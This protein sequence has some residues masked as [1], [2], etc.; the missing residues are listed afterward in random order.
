[1]G[2]AIHRSPWTPEQEAYLREIYPDTPNDEVVRLMDERFGTH[3]T[4][5]SVMH[6][7]RA[8]GIGKSDTFKKPQPCWFWTDEKIAWFREFVP[9]HHEHE[10]SAEHERLYGTPLTASQI[11]NAKAKFGVK[12]G[13]VGGQLRK[14][15]VP[16]N[17]GRTWDECGISA[18]SRERILKTAFK[19]G[20]VHLATNRDH[21]LGYTR[22]GKDGYLEVKVR[23]S[24]IDGPQRQ[25]PG[26]Y[27]E[28]FRFVHHVVWEE[29]NG[30]PVPPHTMIVFADH[31]KRNF[32]PGNLVAVPRSLWSIIS[33]EHWSYRDRES[34]E[35]C[36][37]L[38]K[39]GRAVYAL[40]CHPRDCRACGE[41]FAPRYPH[42]RTCDACLAKRRTEC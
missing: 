33:R 10:I 29:A 2:R 7:A 6:H 13:T 19:P 30:E 17:K 11:G 28:N 16:W 36:M 3:R 39:L 34:L 31:D 20:E 15:N 40:K 12:S 32:D 27:N 35:A 41:T 25:R 1:M 38:A 4:R 18:E 24:R 23:D 5:D 9:G 21:P 37:N 22:I 26:C 42:Q 8:M 14:G